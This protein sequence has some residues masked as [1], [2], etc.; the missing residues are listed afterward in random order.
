M[1]NLAQVDEHKHLLI[2]PSAAFHYSHHSMYVT[3]WEMGEEGLQSLLKLCNLF[4]TFYIP[5][6]VYAILSRKKKS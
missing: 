2:Q 5:L 1:N 6:I 4:I 3:M